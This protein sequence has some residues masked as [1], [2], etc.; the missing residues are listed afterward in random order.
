MIPTR[1][2]IDAAMNQS[3]TR[4]GETA[5]AGWLYYIAGKTQD[6]VARALDVSR[7]S[8]QR[9]VSLCRTDGLISFHLNPPIAACMTLAERLND[10]YGLMHCDVVPSSGDASSGVAVRQI[11]PDGSA[12][13][14]N[15]PAASRWFADRMRARNA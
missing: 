9:L 3:S 14:F 7:P 10:R 6:E 8:P 13:R 1:P 11:S 5:R 4:S 15:E 12:S 2:T